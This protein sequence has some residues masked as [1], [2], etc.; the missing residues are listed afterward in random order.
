VKTP[1]GDSLQ[2]S[3]SQEKFYKALKSNGKFVVEDIPEIIRDMNLETVC[4]E[5]SDG[6]YI[7]CYKRKGDASSNW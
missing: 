3:V 1:G 7:Y 2:I 5:E 4:K 6:Q